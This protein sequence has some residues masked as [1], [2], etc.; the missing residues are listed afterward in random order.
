MKRQAWCSVGLALGLAV[1]GAGGANAPFEDGVPFKPA[2]RLDRLV[3][4]SLQAGGVMP[5]DRC[6][7]AVF[8]RRVHVDIVGALPEAAVV[9]RFLKDGSPDKRARLID[10]LMTQRAFADVRTLKW[11]DL[12]RVKAEFPINLWPNGVQAYA[13]WIHDA[14]T[15]NMPC[16]RF[17][18]ALLT[19]NGSNFRVPPV[20]FYR[21]VQGEKPA[22]LAA[23]AALTFMGARIEAW[24]QERRA[25]MEAFFSRVAFK[26]TA[27]WKEII[28]MPDPAASGPLKAVFPDGREVT[29]GPEEDPRRVFA[30]WLLAPENEWFARNMANRV[31]ARLFGRGLI[32]EPDDIRP[33]NPPVHP[34]VLDYLARELVRERYDLCHVYRLILNS[35]TYQQSSIAIGSQTQAEKLFACYP[36]RRLDAEVLL[37]ALG[38]I[39]GRGEEYMSMIPE[40]FTFVP[41]HRRTIELTDGSISS[42]F[43]KLFGRPSRDTGLASE[44]NNAPSED[45]SLHMLN[46]SQVHSMLTKSA[47]VRRLLRLA[48]GN[49]RKLVERAYLTI[50]SRR[51]T[52]GE[53]QTAVAYIS[54]SR[55]PRDGALDL[56][57]ALVNSK[58]FLTQH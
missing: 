1:A 33:D 48:R 55:N 56:V 2:N 53:E 4:E 17:A 36:V 21:G 19:S 42:P 34:R 35:S 44:R 47:H 39:S 18:R 22:D 50:L 54:A 23:A 32:H 26:G 27:E 43:L 9:T 20:N 51:P 29:I 45:Q 3:L 6:S 14:M 12:L 13:R 7:D 38:W 25:G 41:G 16:D 24:P 30:D 5:A 31:W 37:D 8:V 52:S 46:S 40:P 11:C 57:W 10:H 15:A 58:E 28:V 49:R